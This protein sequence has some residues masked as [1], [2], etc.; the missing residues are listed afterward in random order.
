MSDPRLALLA[1]FVVCL[2]AGGSCLFLVHCR[3]TRLARCGRWLFIGVLFGLG[4]VGVI[5][6]HHRTDAM[7]AL[8]LLTGFLIVAMLWEPAT[9]E[10][11]RPTRS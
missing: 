2:L 7:P 8:G 10:L 11:E 5:A 3:C 4:G 1:F 9:P 6:A